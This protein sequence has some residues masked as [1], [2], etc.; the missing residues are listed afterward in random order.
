[1]KWLFANK[2]A[3]MKGGE[4]I[5]VLLRNVKGRFLIISSLTLYPWVT[6]ML[7]GSIF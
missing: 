3:N 5:Q 6:V 2:E 4:K 7:P 1:M